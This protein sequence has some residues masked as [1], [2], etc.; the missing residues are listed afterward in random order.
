MNPAYALAILASA[1]FGTAD[2][3]GGYAARRISALTVTFASGAAG[4]ISLGIASL[5]LR[6]TAAPADL[7][8]GIAGGV[9]GGLGVALLYRA[10]AIGPMS[11]AAPVISMVALAMPVIVGVAL[12]ERPSALAYGG[13]V[14]AV[15]S[16]PLLSHTHE[17]GA[18]RGAHAQ[19]IMISVASGVLVGGFLVL[20]GRVSPGAGIAPLFAARLATVVLFGTILAIRREPFVPAAGAVQSTLLA[21]VLDSFANVSYYLAVHRA[22]LAI[23]GTIVS[24]SPAATVLLARGVLSEHWTKHQRAGLALAIA[25][26]V[27]VSIG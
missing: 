6:G 19:V 21:G 2:F 3:L 27:C 17:V 11:V 7:A 5:F 16:F 14:M 22:P 12:G 18:S 13:M 23:V 15:A 9:S 10:Y 8:W 25:A 26:I 24:L 20:V 4:L 1:I